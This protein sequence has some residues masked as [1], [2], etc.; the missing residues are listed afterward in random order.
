MRVWRDESWR[1]WAH[2]YQD[3]RDGIAGTRIGLPQ[4]GGRSSQGLSPAL[5]PFS[6]EAARADPIL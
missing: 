5:E 2:R 1:N 3:W 6:T 4:E